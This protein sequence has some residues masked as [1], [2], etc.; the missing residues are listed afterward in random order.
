METLIDRLLPDKLCPDDSPDAYFKVG[1]DDFEKFSMIHNFLEGFNF[2]VYNGSHLCHRQKLHRCTMCQL[3]FP[4]DPKFF[5]IFHGNLIHSGAKAK[6]EDS[7][8]S[9]NYSQDV[10]LFAYIHRTG[11]EKNKDGEET[12]YEQSE[13]L[14]TRR[15]KR[16]KSGVVFNNHSTDA[17]VGVSYQKCHDFKAVNNPTE[18]HGCNVCDN[19]YE[20]IARNYPVTG[21]NICIDIKK[22]YEK[23]QNSK[24][25]ADHDSPLLV[26]GHLDKL[27][28]AV[29]KGQ[30]PGVKGLNLDIAQMKREVHELIYIGP[31]K[32]WRNVSSGRMVYNIDETLPSDKRNIPTTN[33]RT[34]YDS[35]L[36]TVRRVHFFENC[37]FHERYILRNKG[38]VP[39]QNP[40]RD[41]EAKEG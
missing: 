2:N 28:W 35:V 19:A 3:K 18:S 9:F 23:V 8:N 10:R 11:L 33:L 30:E 7:V 21:K 12:S 24:K 39:E 41:Y 16:Q 20:E 1:T 27:G 22:C 37:I 29:Y 40:H 17:A 38:R 13:Q 26:A 6:L 25:S 14:D 15:S 36:D 34:F 4:A 31:E 5:V 32:R